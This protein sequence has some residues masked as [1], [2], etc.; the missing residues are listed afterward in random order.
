MTTPPKVEYQFV[1]AGEGPPPNVVPW[2]VLPAITVA[3]AFVWQWLDM[4]ARLVAAMMLERVNPWTFA[5]LGV[6]V[7]YLL[8]MHLVF[9]VIRG[10]SLANVPFPLFLYP[11]K[12]EGGEHAHWF[13]SVVLLAPKRARVHAAASCQAGSERSSWVS[14]L[15]GAHGD[16]LD[17]GARNL[18]ASVHQRQSRS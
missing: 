10:R 16:S 13:Q 15:R 6:F 9:G 7:L 14:R 12:A 2:L 5:A 17:C 1:K 18:R 4:E 8:N 3:L 11:S